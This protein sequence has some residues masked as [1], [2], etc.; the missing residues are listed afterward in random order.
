[1]KPV[2]VIDWKTGGA[3]YQAASKDWFER[4]GIKLLDV[5]EYEVLGEGLVR[6]GVYLRGEDGKF[7][8][9]GDHLVSKDVL[10]E[11]VDAPPLPPQGTWLRT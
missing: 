3:D 7:S 1:M 5:F 9:D 6:V 4:Y 8:T 2:S 11:S 10:I